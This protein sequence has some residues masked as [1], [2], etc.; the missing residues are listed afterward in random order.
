MK[1]FL[2]GL[3]ML[4]PF[5]SFAQNG[6]NEVLIAPTSNTPYILVDT[7]FTLDNYPATYTDV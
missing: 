6:A 1:K 2:I 5:V 3:V 7:L 4:L